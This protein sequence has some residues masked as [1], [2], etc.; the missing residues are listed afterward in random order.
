MW[1]MY[2]CLYKLYISAVTSKSRGLFFPLEVE[3]HLSSFISRLSLQE[4]LFMI[5]LFLWARPLKKIE[6][7]LHCLPSVPTVLHI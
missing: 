2:R 7:K 4:G 1:K 6:N 3:L 5:D